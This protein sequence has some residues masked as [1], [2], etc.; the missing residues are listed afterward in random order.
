MCFVKFGVGLDAIGAGG[1]STSKPRSSGTEHATR[2]IGSAST[3]NRINFP[4]V[5][6]PEPRSLGPH[7]NKQPSGQSTVPKR[8][9]TSVMEVLLLGETRR[10]YAAATHES[11]GNITQ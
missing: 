8:E 3:T 9:R 4:S 10:G 1:A 11:F 5:A 7:L 6:L 2:T